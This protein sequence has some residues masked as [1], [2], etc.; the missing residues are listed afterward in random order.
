[1][2]RSARVALFSPLIG[3]GRTKWL[4]CAEMPGL[5]KAEAAQW[6]RFFQS[7]QGTL[8]RGVPAHAWTRRGHT[9]CTRTRHGRRCITLYLCIT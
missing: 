8:A 1:V 6:L 9:T 3:T 7:R 2:R 4:D 5:H